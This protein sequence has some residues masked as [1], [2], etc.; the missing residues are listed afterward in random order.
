MVQPSEAV[1]P[2]RRLWRASLPDYPLALLWTPDGSAL[3]ALPATGDLTLLAAEDGRALRHFPGHPGGNLTA[4]WHPTLPLLASGGQDANIHLH[5]LDSSQPPATLAPAKG[6]IETVRWSPDGTHL[7]AAQGKQVHLLRPDLTLV[8][9]FGP[10]PGTVSDLAWAPD[11]RR[12]ATAAYRGATVWNL[13]PDSPPQS[14]DWSGSSLKIAWSPNGAILATGDQT[15]TVHI[16]NFPQNQN[17]CMRGYETKVT[18]LAWSHDSR[19]L[20]TSGGTAAAVWDCS[21]PGP[22]GSE[23]LLLEAHRDSITS[24]A[25]QHHHL[26]LATGAADGTTFVWWPGR[27]PA[28]LLAFPLNSPVTALAWH[29]ND[30]ALA[31]ASADGQLHLCRLPTEAEL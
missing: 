12:L 10:H 2:L 4:H 19:F 11:S 29:P 21:G 30:A 9:S 23:P 22:E 20:A 15:P 17:L 5:S 13:N 1:L 24:L 7:A 27:H 3:L 31:I 14:L 25:F 16:W 6:W 8:R 28:P 18:A 26:L